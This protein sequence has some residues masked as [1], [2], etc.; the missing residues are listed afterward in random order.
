MGQVWAVIRPLLP[1]PAKTGRPRADDRRT[2]E[3][4]L[5]VLRSGCRWQDLPRRYGAPTTVWRRLRTWQEDGTWLRLWRAVLGRLEAGGRLDWGYAFLDGSF[6]PAKRGGDAVGLTRKGKGTKWMLVV[7]GQGIPIG[8]HLASAQKAEVTLAEHALDTVR[9]P[10]E[11]GR[12]RTRPARLVADRAYD[13]A[14]FRA[15]LR[16]RGIKMC[17]PPKCRPKTWRPKRGRPVVARREDYARR[18]TVERT[19]A[20]L[21]NYRRLLIRWERLLAVYQGFMIFAVLLMC[22]SCYVR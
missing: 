15:A 14:A 5:H 9:V 8:L 22:V 16:R 13:S 17:I 7:D 12:P 1:L 20:W 18:W 3:G 21:G 4:I 11:R 19:F 2:L 10:Q 6:A